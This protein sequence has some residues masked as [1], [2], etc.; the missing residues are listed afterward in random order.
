MNRCKKS[1][2]TQILLALSLGL[3]SAVGPL[4]TDA[5]AQ[6]SPEAVIG[7]RNFPTGT[8]RGKLL[9][10]NAP[11][12]MLDG[13]PDRLSPGARIRSPQNML[14]MVG[15]IQG[16]KFLVNYTR[17]PAGL[18]SQVW[19]LTPEEASIERETA[20]RPFLNFWPFVAASRPHDDGKTPF[21]QLPK[22][23]E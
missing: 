20:E 11:E 10:L 1:A 5:Q 14:V 9:I 13:Q 6:I 16:Q 3:A 2:T 7:G 19:I 4:A 8:L 18:V 12:V 15:A 22:Y 17:D 23:G 21:D